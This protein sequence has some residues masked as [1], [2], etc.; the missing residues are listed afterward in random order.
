[1]NSWF[2]S[3][4]FALENKQYRLMWTGTLF[5]FLGMQMQVIT[6]GYLAYELTGRN[7]ALGAVTLAF[8]VPQL[9]LSLVGGVIAD[10]LPKRTVLW[11]S[12][13]IIAVNS[14][15][16]ATMIA[17]DMLEFWQLI[18]A[19]FIQGACFSF[20][21]P[22]RQAFIGDLVGRE[23]IAN[24]VV[25]QQLSM[26]GS[27]VVGP[28]I[29]GAFLGISFI[30]AAGVYYMTTLGFVIA[31]VSMIPLPRGNPRPRATETSPMA[32]IMDGLRYM[33][34]RPQIAALAM[35]SLLVLTIG[36]PYQ[37]FLASVVLGEYGATKAAIGWLSSAGAV[38]GVVATVWVAS[39]TNSRKVW[40][41]QPLMGVL[42]GFTVMALG[43]SPNLVTGLLVMLFVGATG[44]AFQTLNTSLT[45]A[46]ADHEYHG[47]VQSLTGLGWSF[48]GIAALPIGF[49][50][51]HVGLRE[52]LVL[53]GALCVV[54]VLT[55]E[56][57]AKSRNVA[58]DRHLSTVPVAREVRGTTG[59]GR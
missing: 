8:G 20:V 42:F 18:L 10:R 15:W 57:V 55:V 37:S 41:I 52:T 22:A 5:S 25:L 26:N 49:V 40:M 4:F 29:A 27:R 35:T 12:Q 16:V 30:G 14:A 44:A 50:A 7:S 39:I 21:G 9:M 34:G 31:I 11:V 59:G 33:R 24:A 45:M 32:D 43:A 48:F 54:S 38:G 36:F 13:S 3:T 2:H 56:L 51:D 19:G 58:R 6:R 53:M 1:M 47:R 28:S 46:L 23:R 17:F